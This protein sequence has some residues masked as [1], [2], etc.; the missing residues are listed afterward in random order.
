MTEVG[1]LLCSERIDDKTEDSC[2]KTY[3]WADISIVDENDCPVPVGEQGQILLRPNGANCFML[4]YINK[5]KET[6]Q[7]WRNLLYC[8]NAYFGSRSEPPL[9]NSG[10]SRFQEMANW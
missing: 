6:I 9:Q 8:R 5:P 3:G 2:G 7:A 10:N 4:E 1:V